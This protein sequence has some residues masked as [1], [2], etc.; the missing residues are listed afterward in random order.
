MK[1]AAQF[2]GLAGVIYL[3]YRDSGM[4]G[5]ADNKHPDSL[6]MAS[7]DEVASLIVKI[8]RELRPD[9]VVT[10]DAGGGYG[11]PDHIATHN[12]VIKAFYAA[13]APT[14]YSALLICLITSTDILIDFVTRVLLVSFVNIIQ[15]GVDICTQK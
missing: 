10:H 3:G 11:H 5:S 1:C 15:T 2:P 12:A 7:I 13:V 9:V 14:Q 4:R 6:A 8:I